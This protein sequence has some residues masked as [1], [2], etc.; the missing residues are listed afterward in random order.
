MCK[1]QVWGCRGFFV[2]VND[3]LNLLELP[4][5]VNC[6]ECFQQLMQ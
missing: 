4:A 5:V 1:N 3:S 6:L 2:W